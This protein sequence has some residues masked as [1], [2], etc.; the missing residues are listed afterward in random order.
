ML[1]AFLRRRA[2]QKE[3]EAQT[4]QSTAE[5]GWRDLIG[6]SSLYLL[7]SAFS[8]L[9]SFYLGSTGHKEWSGIADHL[10][11]AFFV[12]LAL[13]IGLEHNAKKRAYRELTRHLEEL[14]R[15]REKVDQDVFEAVL[16]RVVPEAIAEEVK[17]TLRI[18]VIK[19]D[20]EYV[21]TLHEPE[22]PMPPGYAVL[23][24]DLRFRV[25]NL[26]QQP[27][28]FPVLS[29]YACDE[30]LAS[31]AWQG[32]PFHVALEVDG[33]PI[34]PKPAGDEKG[35]VLDHTVPLAPRGSAEIFLRGEEPIRID[36]GR[37]SYVQST[38]VD[39]L[40]VSIQNRLPL[41]MEVEVQMHHPA[42]KEVSHDK[43]LDRYVLKRAFLPGQGFEVSWKKK[44][45][46]ED[47]V[48]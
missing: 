28:N 27:I 21:I 11:I 14:S 41:A 16:G 35:F 6:L 17:Q 30:D 15:Y 33:N 48:F 23:R 29:Y 42:W 22:Q 20:C 24:R 39:A 31:A 1:F 44:A 36:A 10:S 18:P 19:S 47:P 38:P 9:A 45:A 40:T 37:S 26:L 32:R 7:L 12:A 3:E 25:T 2:P 5:L 46:R 8:Y 43:N 34:A 13:L 4:S